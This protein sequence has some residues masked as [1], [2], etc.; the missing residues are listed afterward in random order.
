VL[1]AVLLA[2]AA[3]LL[4]VLDDDEG[5]FADQATT[6]C[7]AAAQ[8]VRDELALSFPEGPPSAAAEAEYLGQAFADAMDDLVADL[9]ALDGSDAAAEAVDALE[10]RIAEIRD[11]PQRFVDAR[12]DPFAED[13]APRFDE[14]DLPACGSEFFGG[15]A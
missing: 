12:A 4:F 1:A 11:D 9:R 10:A 6:T 8:R 7:E 15:S 3:V 2:V 5:D 13:V 14:L